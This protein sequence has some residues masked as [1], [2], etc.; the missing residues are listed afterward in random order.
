MWQQYRKN[1]LATQFFILAICGSMIFFGRMSV[2][3]VV[4]CFIVMQ[5]GGLAGSAW[6]A[7]LKRR[8]AAAGERRLRPL[9]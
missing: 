9:L 4:A 6:G 5:F 2:M 1:V 7:R 3:T 8:V